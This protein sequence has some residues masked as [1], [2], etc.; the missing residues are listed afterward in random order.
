[1]AY[2]YHKE[3][4]ELYSNRGGLREPTEAEKK[5]ILERRQKV[6]KFIKECYPEIDLNK[7]TLKKKQ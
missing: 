6:S 4:H 7:T 2:K 3:P 5:W 1:M